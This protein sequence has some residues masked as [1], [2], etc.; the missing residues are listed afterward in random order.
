M[1]CKATRVLRNIIRNVMR[2]LKRRV[3]ILIGKCVLFIHLRFYV[4]AIYF[5]GVQSRECN[6]VGEV[7]CT[8]RIGIYQRSGRLRS[9]PNLVRSTASLFPQLVTVT[10][11]FPPQSPL[12]RGSYRLHSWHLTQLTE[13]YRSRSSL[14]LRI[15][16]LRA[17]IIFD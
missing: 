1:T 11:S 5:A 13:C 14:R 4:N 3:E 16:V 2:R 17:R 8:A 10:S 12:S 9:M 6:R 15:L 7:V